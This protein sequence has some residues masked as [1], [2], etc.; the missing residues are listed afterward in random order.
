MLRINTEKLYEKDDY[1]AYWEGSRFTGIGYELGAL[2]QV[3][4]ETV[5][6]NGLREG[7]H[8]VFGNNR[9]LLE[10]GFYADNKPHGVWKKWNEEGKLKKLYVFEHGVKRQE[11]EFDAHGS[12]VCE[13]HYAM[14]DF[15]K[16]YN[17]YCKEQR[18]YQNGKLKE[19]KI[20]EY[21]ILRASKKWDADGTLIQEYVID[22]DN[23]K[24]IYWNS[25]KKK[26]TTTNPFDFSK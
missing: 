13:K 26:S 24:Y 1:I 25:F 5:Y 9:A 22:T 14:L 15:P 23:K 2:G 17:S 8:Q 10:E 11:K 16:I 4:E 21:D 6:A 3:C 12:I 19:E 20:Y 7:R 18:Y